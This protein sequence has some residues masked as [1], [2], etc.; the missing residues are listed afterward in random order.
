MPLTVTLGGPTLYRIRLSTHGF[1][2]NWRRTIHEQLN[3]GVSQASPAI[4]LAF[5][6]VAEHEQFRIGSKVIE[7][8]EIV[9]ALSAKVI[10]QNPVIGPDINH[11]PPMCDLVSQT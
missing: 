5:R 8:I 3:G 2:S 7:K 11:A 4:Q 9:F 6:L 1:R 10:E